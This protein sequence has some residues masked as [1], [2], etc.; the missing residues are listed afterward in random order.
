MQVKLKTDVLKT[1]QIMSDDNLEKQKM[2]Y[3]YSKFM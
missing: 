2:L 1:A 3:F